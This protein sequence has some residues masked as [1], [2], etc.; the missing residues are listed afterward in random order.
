MNSVDLN[1]IKFL[2]NFIT[3]HPNIPNISVDVARLLGLMTFSDEEKMDAIIDF[4]KI[5]LDQLK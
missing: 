5:N 2:L 3:T 4:L 1:S